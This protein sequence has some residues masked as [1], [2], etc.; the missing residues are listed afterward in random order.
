MT[1]SVCLI[2]ALC[3]VFAEH[4]WRYDKIQWQANLPAALQESRL[5][6]KPILLEFSSLSCAPCRQ[7][8]SETLSSSEIDHLAAKFI[9]VRLDGFKDLKNLRKYNVIAIPCMLILSSNGAIISRTEGLQSAD[10]FTQFLSRASGEA[11][12]QRS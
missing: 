11:K 10:D 3:A 2:I 8:D 5:K 4:P 1:V 6:S 7:F 9:P 12:V